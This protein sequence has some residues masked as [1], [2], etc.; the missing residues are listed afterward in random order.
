MGTQIS[1]CCGGQ[2]KDA[3]LEIA[4][5]INKQGPHDKVAT[6]D[7]NKADFLAKIQD[8]I[9]VEV[10]LQDKSKLKCLMMYNKDVASLILSCDNKTR[11][12]PLADVKSV[13]HTMDQLKR[14]ETAAGILE[15]DPC[16]AIHLAQSGNCI[17]LFFRTVAEKD[18][19]VELVA[20]YKAAAAG[21]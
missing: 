17:P 3:Q 21:F 6:P 9:D 2:T 11:N 8:G 14:V 20:G 1:G 10:I 5:H 16:A 18:F 12:I 4:T 13:L 15:G 7:N 19:F